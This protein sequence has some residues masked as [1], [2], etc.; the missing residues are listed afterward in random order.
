V[1]EMQREGAWVRARA[2]EAARWRRPC[3][4]AAPA[5]AV[6]RCG[7]GRGGRRDGVVW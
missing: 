4:A 7:D 6:V 5:A 2:R 1:E 3:M